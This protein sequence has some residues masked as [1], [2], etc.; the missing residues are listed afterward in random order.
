MGNNFM[1]TTLIKTTSRLTT[2]VEAIALDTTAI[3]SLDWDRDR[4][5]SYLFL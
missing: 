1:V 4:L 5:A 2:Q 3:C